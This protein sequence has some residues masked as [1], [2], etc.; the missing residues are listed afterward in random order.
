VSTEG[1]EAALREIGIPCR[2]EAHERLAVLIV[3]AEARARTA[4]EWRRAAVRLAREH[5]FTHVALE[6]PAEETRESSH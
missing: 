5:G 3:S 1:L 6:L 2:V 4:R